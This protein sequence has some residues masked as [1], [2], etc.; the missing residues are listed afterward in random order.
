MNNNLNYVWT[1]QIDGTYI[2]ARTVYYQ[3]YGKNIR[4]ILE[5]NVSEKDYFLRKLSG[6]G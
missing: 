6:E 2:K 5:E 1:R 4:H 3:V